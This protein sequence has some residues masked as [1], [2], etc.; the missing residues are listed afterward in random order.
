[1]IVYIFYLYTH[2]YTSIQ[3]ANINP[4]TFPTTPH[5]SDVSNSVEIQLL[6]ACTCQVSYRPASSSGA[7][8]SRLG[9]TGH[10]MF[11]QRTFAKI[12]TYG[13]VKYVYEIM[14]FMNRDEI[15]HVS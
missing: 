12:T 14:G 4:Y 5:S 1:M 6:G 8:P 10:H 15:D 9:K 7:W 3:F 13:D 11:F 2:H